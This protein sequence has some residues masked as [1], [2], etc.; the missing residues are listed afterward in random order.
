MKVILISIS[1]SIGL[2]IAFLLW[3][4]DGKLSK[5]RYQFGE[6]QKNPI[7][8][9]KTTSHQLNIITLNLG[10]CGGLNGLD[11]GRITH[12][13]SQ[14]R[15]QKLVNSLPKDIDILVVQEIDQ[16]SARSG[17]HNQ[18]EALAQELQFNYHA[19]A[20]TWDK[21]WIPYPLH[22][23]PN[24][25]FGQT[26]AGQVIFSKH[27]IKF[28]KIQKFKKPNSLPFWKKWFYLDRLAQHTHIHHP[29]IGKINLTHLHLE[30][31][32]SNSRNKQFNLTF[33]TLQKKRTFQ[34]TII[35]GD[36]NIDFNKPLPKEIKKKPLQQFKEVLECQKGSPT[37]PSH[38]PTERIDTAWISQDW[39]ILSAK[40]VETTD[41][42]SGEIS[43]HLP[44]HIVLEFKEKK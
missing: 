43:D 3:S 5:H 16:A 13:I 1:I 20:Y 39:T 17:F 29:I 27:P 26:L 30:A 33:N 4:N 19:T 32:D 2:I 22:R 6:I 7:E 11:G 44:L 23:A 40:T 21:R 18:I 8:P 15:I 28:Q 36:F 25:Q 10:F 9:Y 31:F 24:K 12:E 37:Y 42:K 35:I 34:K 38:K 41:L 14:N